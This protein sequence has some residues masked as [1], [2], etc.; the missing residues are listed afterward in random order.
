MVSLHRKC[1]ASN[2]VTW[3]SHGSS[4]EEDCLIRTEGQ[5][6]IKLA[7]PVHF[8]LCCTFVRV[9]QGRFLPHRIWPGSFRRQVCLSNCWSTKADHNSSLCSCSDELKLNCIHVYKMKLVL[10]C[11]CEFTYLLLKPPIEQTIGKAQQQLKNA[12]SLCWEYYWLS[13]ITVLNS[14]Y[15]V[16]CEHI[17][18]RKLS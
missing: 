3:N 2:G 16:S 6:L 18:W 14:I 8:V 5:R 10:C 15:I 4:R 11:I 12:F 13:Y 9:I 7:N 17:W 1:F